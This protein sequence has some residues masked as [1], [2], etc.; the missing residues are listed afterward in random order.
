[1]LYMGEQPKEGEITI[2][3]LGC[4]IVQEIGNNRE[5]LFV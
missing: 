5:G 4:K 1:M 3:S 2:A